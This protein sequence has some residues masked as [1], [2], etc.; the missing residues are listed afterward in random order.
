MASISFID[1]SSSAPTGHAD[2]FYTP[3][4]QSSSSFQMNPLSSHPPRLQP[5]SRQ[6]NT[7]D[8]LSTYRNNATT[9]EKVPEED[10]EIDE[11]QDKVK[12]MECRIQ[13][14]DVWREM[15][16]TSNGRDKAFKIMQYSIR[17]YLLVHTSVAASR[18][19]RRRVRP[20]WE[21][22]I[23]NRLGSTASGLSF[24]RKLLLLFNWLGPLTSIMAQQSAPIF[25][26]R[27]SEAKKAKQQPF[28]HS[29]LHAPPPVLLEFVHA[30]A[31]DA[32]TYSRLGLFGK[33]FGE[34]AERFSNWCWLLATLVGL[35]ENGVE[36]QIIGNLQTEVESRLYTESMSGATAKSNP[37][38]TKIDEK[39]LQ[40]LQ[41]QDYWL[42][43]T[44]GKLVMDLIFVVYDLFD[45][46][47][48]REPVKTLSGLAAAILS[49]AKLY[50]RHK[51]L[52]LKKMMIA[53]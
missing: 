19:A 1:H 37:R 28:L 16:V 41:R 18:F 30:I 45:I 4:F 51:T 47:R 49:S 52:L 50:D 15:F 29:V 10:V 22:D 8:S 40:R 48:A 7:F 11:E 36:R 2:N 31:D 26:E 39:E 21:A 42:K 53:P 43:M 13:K 25:L 33:K 34:R 5:A 3:P 24:T 23:L 44:R 32:V 27:S 35:V 9:E 12:H 14:E 38:A 20:P 46:K 6:T 17:V